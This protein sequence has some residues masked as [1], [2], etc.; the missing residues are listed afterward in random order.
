[1]KTGQSKIVLWCGAAPNQKALA[2]KIAAEYNLAGIVI[3]ERAGGTLKQ[4]KWHQ[5]PL[6]IVDRIRFKTI[7]D[8]WKN[9]MLYYNQ[10]FL[11][12]PDLPTIRTAINSK[13]AFDF[14]SAI[15]PDLIVVSGTAMVKEPM[16][17]CPST[18]GVI[19]LHTGL[20]PYVKG[21]PNC[22]NWC[23]ANNS[24]HLVGNTIMWINAGIDAGNIIATETIDIRTAENL[25]AAH[26][27][28]MN[29]AHDL[30]LRTIKYLLTSNPPY[31]SVAQKSIAKGEL[32]LT[33]MWTA[34]KRSQLLRNWKNREKGKMGEP[35]VT[36]SLPQ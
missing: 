20:S 12:W 16:L 8:A 5:I 35:P 18:L 36:V 14:T 21:A 1:M 26:V 27:S 33:K 15:A 11:N 10:L 34:K 24:W 32:F 25:N 4:H 13:E 22:T 28:V 31:N 19:N 17:S 2:C 9:L 3:D 30:Y 23:I 29:H 7:Y 6:L